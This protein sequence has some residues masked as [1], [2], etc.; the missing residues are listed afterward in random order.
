MKNVVALLGL[1][2]LAVACGA[3]KLWGVDVGKKEDAGEFERLL[4]RAGASDEGAG[5][6]GRAAP[7]I[8][9]DIEQAL[10]ALA[11]ADLSKLSLSELC[12]SLIDVVIE[13]IQDEEWL[14]QFA[15]PGVI[16]R[17]LAS[18][19]LYAML[20]DES[21]VPVEKNDIL[22]LISLEGSPI[23][24]KTKFYE[25]AEKTIGKLVKLRMEV[26]DPATLRA[27]LKDMLTTIGLDR[28]QLN[29]VMEII[30]H[31]EMLSNLINALL[32]DPTVVPELTKAAETLF[33]AAGK[34]LFDAASKTLFNAASVFE[35]SDLDSDEVSFATVLH[36]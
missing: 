33:N 15:E 10:A 24:Y 14:G 21:M 35:D 25:L 20:G 36:G 11:D 18:F 7:G 6:A 5:G 34:T 22:E 27:M 19:G 29:Q 30:E 26:S 12:T 31:P 13:T 4:Q 1:L 16:E 28:E 3:K 2:L 8:A 17:L 23:L 32:G 9:D